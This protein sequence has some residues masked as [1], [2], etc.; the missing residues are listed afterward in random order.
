M[1][2]EGAGDALFCGETLF[3]GYRIRSDV[4]GHQ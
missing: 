2:F 3:A 1:F 4:P